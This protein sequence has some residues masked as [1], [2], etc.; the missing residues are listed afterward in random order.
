[1]WSHEC[2]YRICARPQLSNGRQ[3]RAIHPSHAEPHLHSLDAPTQRLVVL[4]CHLWLTMKEMKEADKIPFLDAPISSGSLFGPA[5]EGFAECFTEAQKSSQAMRHLLPKRTSSS[6][7][8]SCARPVSTQQ[9]AEPTPFTP[10]PR[11]RK[12][13]RSARRNPFLKR[14]GLRPKIALDLAPQKSS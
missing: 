10:E 9:T 11:P 1:M 7:A 8:S 14:Q 6:A 13:S 3:W 12:G 5:V 2:V 4:E